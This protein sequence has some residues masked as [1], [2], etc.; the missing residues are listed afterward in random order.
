MKTVTT[1]ELRNTT[2]YVDFDKNNALPYRVNRDEFFI[3]SKKTLGEA[4]EYVFVKNQIEHLK[5]AL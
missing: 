2:W 3:I 4:L 5:L 1:I